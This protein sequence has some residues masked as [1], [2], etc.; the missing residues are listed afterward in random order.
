MNMPTP[1]YVPDVEGLSQWLRVQADRRSNLD[2]RSECLGW[3]IAVEA[4]AAPQGAPSPDL[5]AKEN[6]VQQAQQWAQEARTQRATVLDILRYFGLPENDWE[7]LR[8]IKERLVVQPSPM[9]ELG[10]AQIMAAT[11]A[12]LVAVAEQ[13]NDEGRLEEISPDDVN[14]TSVQ[15]KRE[16]IRAMLATPAASMVGDRLAEP[17]AQAPT[18][19]TE[20]TDPTAY[21]CTFPDGCSMRR[22]FLLP[23]AVAS[24]AHHTGAT[25]TPLYAAPRLAAPV[26]GPQAPKLT[27]RFGSMPESNGKANWTATLCRAGDDSLRALMDGYGFARSEYHDRVRYEADCMRF[28]IG[29]LDKEPDILAYDA[30]MLSPPVNAGKT[31]PPASTKETL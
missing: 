19:P 4:L 17:V 15:F 2:G 5:A 24:Y 9:P 11:E 20:P 22:E 28:L 31:I 26:A 7:A 16:F 3:A 1:A 6:V 27:V 18:E 21:E 14:E 8:L 12:A 13:I 29:E 10:D 23:E 30:D 25:F